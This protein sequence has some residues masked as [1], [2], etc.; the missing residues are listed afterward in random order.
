MAQCQKAEIGMGGLSKDN[1]KGA[2]MCNIAAGHQRKRQNNI[3]FPKRQIVFARP[4]S[5]YGSAQG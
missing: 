3:T 4:S 2:K 5:K 1:A